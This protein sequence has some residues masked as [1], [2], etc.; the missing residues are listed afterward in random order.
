[1]ESNRRR[2]TLLLFCLLA[3]L[4][5]VL[6]GYYYWHKPV[7][8]SMVIP[9]LLAAVD[10]LF[11]VLFAGIAGGLGRFLLR[12]KGPSA[13]EYWVVQF[14]LGASAISF[15]WFMLGL[16]GLYWLPLAAPLLL[17]GIVLLR[18]Q[19]R[20][21]FS[22]AV[23][24]RRG[25]Q[26]AGRI[27]KILA[28]ITAAL[29]VFQ[30]L[31][32]LAPPIKWDALAYHL[33]LPRQY[34]EA[35]RFYFTPENPYWGHP[36][37]VEML[38]TLAMSFHRAETAALLNWSAGV[39]FLI[40][41][42]GFTNAAL[43]RLQNRP[44]GIKAGI[45]AI[46]AVM[47]GET[48]R[49]L[50]GWSYTDVFSALYGLAALTLVFHWFETRRSSAFWLAALLAGLAI[51]TKWTSGV[52]ALSIM[53]AGLVWGKKYGL[54]RKNWLTAGLV[55]VLAVSPWLIKN[56]VVTGN[57]VYPYFFSTA[58]VDLE[59]FAGANP[60]PEAIEWWMHLLLP[61]SVTWTGIDSAAG[62][63]A[64]IGPLLLLLCV[65]G[66]IRY[67]HDDR[68]KSLS[69]LLLFTAL[70]IGLGGLRYSFLLQTRLYYV[71][72]PAMAVTAGWGW[73]WL[74]NQVVHGVRMRRIIGVMVLLVMGMA[75][76]KDSY[77]TAAY[78]PLDVLIGTKT[79]QEYLEN[80]IGFTSRAMD[81]LNAMP[82]DTRTLLLWEP[83]GLYAP[84]NAQP[85]L[86]IDRWRTDRRRYQQA[87]A[88]VQ[89]WKEQGFTHVMIFQH[90]VDLIR[91]QA[92]QPES[93]DWL[94][95]QDLLEMLPQPESIGDF[96]LLYPLD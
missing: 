53:T 80:T 5:V 14:A 13:L 85:D 40:G 16:L 46:T 3:W 92:D 50:L 37:P 71:A 66:F 82:Q 62:F 7:N 2:E 94:V 90:G 27:E 1:M 11:V 15:L 10:I 78:A 6:F 72:L 21:W 36:Q 64:D 95:F 70:G 31:I 87:P 91:P 67:W 76:W 58:W 39:I 73:E 89:H 54:A 88:I 56:L 47:A 42:F 18:R 48:F 69:I 24:L 28:G 45:A 29:L 52:L 96:Y 35:G 86:W 65:P 32:A 55:I 83:R 79:R 74:Q 60:P 22:S 51:G 77:L 19:A 38:Y 34:L 63:S 20:E 17:V 33:Q 30:L 59:R 75:L 41:L 93:L 44:V 8:V 57:P 9:P 68:V 49:V 61:F 26:G 23:V 43:E 81:R 12:A 4:L 84:S 25:W